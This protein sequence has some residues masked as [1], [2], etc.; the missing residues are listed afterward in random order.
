[1]AEYYRTRPLAA[2]TIT[3]NSDPLVTVSEFDKHR[4]LLL[5][6][7]VE[8]GWVPE[9]RRYLETIHRDIKK[10]EDIVK[11]WQV[12]YLFSNT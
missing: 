10:D 3:P 11:W 5:S 2:P 4:E 6:D 7:D 9:L 8:E 1:M 12:C